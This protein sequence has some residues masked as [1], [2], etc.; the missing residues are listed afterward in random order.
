MVSVAPER[1][2]APIALDVLTVVDRVA[3]NLGFDYFVTGAMARDILLY[4]VFGLETGRATR[5][6]DIAVAVDSWREFGAIKTR[7]I[8][9]GAVIADDNRPHR[10]FY[11][12]GLQGHRYP[13]DLLPFGGIERPPSHI[14]WPPDLSI[15]MNVAGYREAF[16]AAEQVELRPRFVVRIA[17][18]PGLAILKLFAWNDRGSEDSRDAL[19]FGVLLHSYG[20]AGTEDRLFGEEMPLLEAV[21]YNI[22]LAGPRLLGKDAT[23]IM[24]P[25]TRAQIVALLDNP[26]RRDRLAK[27]MAKVFRGAED[28]I[29]K[30][31]V[32]IAQFRTGLAEI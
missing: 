29:A 11:R 12:A 20:D 16:A 7:L 24:A 8:E 3:Q 22:D 2:V 25:S 18:L 4:H 23:R 13:F 32:A 26:A 31:D 5:D 15:V 27:D 9:T 21:D 17:S 28:P 1:P 30:A 14:T 6:V 10:L 19:D